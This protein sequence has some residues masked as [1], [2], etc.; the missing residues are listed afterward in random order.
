[1]EP[2]TGYAIDQPIVWP[3]TPNWDTPVNETLSFLTDVMRATGTGSEQAR[4]LRDEPRRGFSFSSLVAGD[5]QRIVDAIRFDIGIRQFLLPIYPDQQW[6]AAALDAGSDGIDCRTAGFDFEAGVQAVLWRDA[7]NWELVTVDSIADGS[8][9]FAAATANAWGPGDRLIPARKARLSDIPKA[10]R[11]SDDI[12]ALDISVLI[13]EPC[14]WPAAWPTATTYRDVPVLEWRNE[15]SD[16]PTDEYDRMS[17][18]VDQDVGPLYYFDLPAMPFRAQSQSFKLFGRDKHSS[19]RSLVYMLEGQL[20]QLWMPTWL[21]D[22]RLTQALASNAT[23]LHVPWMG[24]SQFSYL[25]VNRRDIAIELNDGTRFYRR[26]T[27]SAESGNEEIL[28]IDSELGVDLDPS[29]VRA[30]GWLSVCASASD[31]TQIQHQDDADGRAY[32]AINWRA[33]KTDV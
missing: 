25:Q 18:T 9:A 5:V 4:G 21:Q 3:C 1:V 7:M 32:S 23:Q 31:T 19:F 6:L 12:V 28:Q 15:E 2:V 11:H 22:V 29:A 26:I 33:L 24:Y 27:G 20:S 10:T 8:I 16:D 17:G 14:D 13:D 30:I